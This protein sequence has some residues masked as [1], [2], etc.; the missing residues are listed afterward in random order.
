MKR[1]ISTEEHIIEILK[2]QD[3]GVPV[4]D[5]LGLTCEES[6]QIPSSFVQKG[7][8][9]L[10]MICHWPVAEPVPSQLHQMAWST[11]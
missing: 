9:A 11:S 6:C 1:N 5:L 10:F 8:L 3:V 7:I 2:D 4:T